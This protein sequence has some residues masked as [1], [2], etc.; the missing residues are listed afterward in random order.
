MV[1]NNQW[2]VGTPEDC[3]AGIERL[4]ETSGG[5][6]GFMMRV[7]DWVQREKTLRSYE[8]FA[9]HVMPHFQGSL[10]GIMASNHWAR[11]RRKQLHGHASPGSSRPPTLISRSAAK[12][13][14]ADPHGF[15][16]RGTR[17]R[18]PGPTM[19]DGAGRPTTDRHRAAAYSR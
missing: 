10:S 16:A 15:G 18:A 3:I 13:V 6:G 11:E 8:L 17:L 1:E 14:R 2:I 12:P 19:R 4:Q 5:F 9:R 7:D